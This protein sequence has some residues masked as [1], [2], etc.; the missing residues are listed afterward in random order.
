MLK[1]R[2]DLQEFYRKV[3]GFNK[4][5]EKALRLGA[6]G[7]GG[8][9]V[10]VVSFFFPSNLLIRRRYFLSI[11]WVSRRMPVSAANLDLICGAE[12]LPAANTVIRFQAAAAVPV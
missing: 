1:D 9:T 11:L 2:R 10:V 5:M 8:A 7:R 4:D 3:S 6:H 12:S